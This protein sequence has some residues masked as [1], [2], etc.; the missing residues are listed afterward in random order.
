MDINSFQKNNNNKK[1]I[2]LKDW[3]Y[4]LKIKIIFFSIKIEFNVLKLKSKL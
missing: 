3:L 2:I 4:I 1:K